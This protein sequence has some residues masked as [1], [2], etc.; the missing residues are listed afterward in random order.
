MP[1]FILPANFGSLNS[2]FWL[3]SLSKLSVTLS[4][5]GE[6]GIDA[7]DRPTTLDLPYGFVQKDSNCGKILT[8]PATRPA[9]CGT[10]AFLFLFYPGARVDDAGV[11]D[12]APGHFL[13]RHRLPRHPSVVYPGAGVEAIATA[14]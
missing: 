11:E 10:G 5:F 6:G 2:Y 7:L 8:G 13:P 12:V 4:K 1:N 9:S 3:K 14:F